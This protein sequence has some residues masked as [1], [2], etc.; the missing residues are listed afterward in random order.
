M[1]PG[2]AFVTFAASDGAEL[3]YALWPRESARGTV[4]LLGGFTEF[5]EKHFETVQDLLDRGF[6][7]AAMDWRS[8]GL[9]QR[10][11]SNPQKIHATSFRRY[12]DD[13][14]ELQE[15]IVGLA[16]PGP[17][18]ILAHSMGGHIALRYL[19]NRPPAIRGTVLSSPMIDIALPARLRWA[20]GAIVNGA[21]SLGFDEAYAPGARD[22]GPW[23]QQFEGNTLTSDPVRFADAHYWIARNPALASGGGTYGWLKAALRS[24]R[25]FEDR[26]YLDLFRSPIC[27]VQA[28]ADK[29]VS[30]TAQD[31]FAERVPACELHRIE[32]ARHELLKERDALRNQFWVIFDAFVS[33]L[34]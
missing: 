33:K 5:I 28:G 18:F 29:V 6:A 14:Q 21:V 15:R 25:L 13:L 34:L 24:I 1:P 27:L 7:V 31:R 11:V 23:K 17:Y 10:S 16:L 12:A 20:I 22:Y 3:R 32:G 9:S 4:T 2:G 8:Q 19:H 30:N 26:A